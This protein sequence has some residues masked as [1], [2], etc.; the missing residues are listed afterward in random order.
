MSSLFNPSNFS[1]Y[2][3]LVVGVA[4]AIGYFRS[5]AQKT[6]RE[7]AEGLKT[8]NEALSQRADR[9][10]EE[11]SKTTAQLKASEKRTDLTQVLSLLSEQHQGATKLLTRIADENQTN[12]TATH[13]MLRRIADESAERNGHIAELVAK[14]AAD[15]LLGMK[16]LINLTTETQKTIELLHE[17]R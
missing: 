5:Q 2:I 10:A 14:N 9:I 3:L 13:E 17:V 4:A 16:E 11:L 6:W 7:T 15:Q 8:D 1:S 12:S